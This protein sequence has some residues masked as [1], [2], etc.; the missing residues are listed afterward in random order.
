M[1]APMRYVISLHKRSKLTIVAIAIVIMFITSITS[2]IYSFELSN[3]ELVE[4]FQSKYHI[5]S[6]SEDLLKSKINIKDVRGAY[7]TLLKVNIG[8][9]ETYLAGIYDPYK[10]LESKYECKMN[11]IILEKSFSTRNNTVK[12]LWQSGSMWLKVKRVNSL[13]IF[14][15]YWG[16]ANFS[17]VNNITHRVNFIITKE[18]FEIQGYETYSMTK[19]NDFYFKNVEEITWDL[20]FLELISIVVIYIFTNTLLNMEVRENIRKMG[21][22]KAIGSSKRNIASLYLLRSIYIGTSGMLLGFSLGVVLSY[23]L[24]TFIPMLGISTYFVVYIPPVIFLIDVL[25]GVGGSFLAS[26][27]PVRKAVKVNI[28]AGLGGGA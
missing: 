8:G 28:L 5:I 10:I 18:R 26:I 20:I 23:I 17:L 25:L 3:K 11:E 27:G 9:R 6:S 7:V 24:T 16:I 1:I 14:P 21:I 22:M 4:R 12:I 13:D 15:E 19:L 2:I